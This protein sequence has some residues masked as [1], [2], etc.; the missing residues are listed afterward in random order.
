MPPRRHKPKNATIV[1]R[2][3]IVLMRKSG[4]VLAT[5]E[6]ADA[7]AAET[8]A[9]VQFELDEQQRRGACLCRSWPSDCPHATP[10][11]SGPVRGDRAGHRGRDIQNL[12]GGAVLVP[13]AVPRF[14]NSRVWRPQEGH[15]EGNGQRPN[16]LK[17][18]SAALT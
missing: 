14:A 4:D 5:V 9:A 8:G 1:R 10:H 6:A 11:P 12:S 17:F 13:Y 16:W 7:N 18:W 15:T 2:S 3:R